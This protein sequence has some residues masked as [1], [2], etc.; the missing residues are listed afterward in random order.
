MN[1]IFADKCTELLQQYKENQRG[2][3]TI[4]NLSV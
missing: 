2:L 4:F 3:N 1:A